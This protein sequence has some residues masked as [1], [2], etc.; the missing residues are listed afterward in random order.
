MLEQYSLRRSLGV[1]K[2]RS[3]FF[4]AP[5]SLDSLYYRENYP[6]IGIHFFEDNFFVSVANYNKLMLSKE[7]LGRYFEYEFVMMMHTD[8][9]LFRDSLDIW[10]NS[11]YDYVGAPWP[12]GMSQVVG[13]DK[14]GSVPAGKSVKAPVGNGGLSLRRVRKCIGLLNEF[15]QALQIYL[16]NGHNEDVFFA[17]MGQ[18]SGDFV[19]PNEMTAATFALELSPEFYY[20]VNKKDP[21][22]VHA[23]WKYS[24]AFWIKRLNQLDLNP[25]VNEVIDFLYRNNRHAEVKSIE[26]NVPYLTT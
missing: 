8:A 2:D 21:M 20:A 25:P 22:G 9:I 23:W 12:D 16:L 10:E 15:P 11:P 13:V 24:P 17:I 26:S 3:I 5:R 4:I 19:I 7:F 14:L 6:T 1:L 18:L